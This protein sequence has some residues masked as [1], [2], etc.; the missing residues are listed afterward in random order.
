VSDC[1]VFL[2]FFIHLYAKS[3]FLGQGNSICPSHLPAFFC[4]LGWFHITKI[5]C[6]KRNG[7]K[8]W[9][10]RLEKIDLNEKSWWEP[11]QSS[12]Q[13]Q[14]ATLVG[15][16]HNSQE[17]QHPGLSVNMRRLYCSI[18]YKASDE[19]YNLGWTCMN[20]SCD[21]Y[22]QFADYPDYEDSQLDYNDAFMKNRTPFVGANPGPLA[23]A[24][25]TNRDIDHLGGVGYE[26]AIRKGIVCQ[27]C[28]CCSRRQHWDH[29][30]CENPNCDFTY[31]V[32]Q[33][34][35][36]ISEVWTEK[37]KQ[38][39]PRNVFDRDSVTFSKALCGHY[40]S[41]TYTVPGENGETIGRIHHY[42]SNAVINQQTDGPNDLF[43]LMQEGKFNLKR[44]SARGGNGK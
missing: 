7:H 10:T 43:R 2:S 18:C 22:F 39:T 19:I 31:S 15:G 38:N 30:E 16:A 24:P 11:M 4:V 13:V 36:T 33:N 12:I 44:N 3:R 17:V 37:L 1:H 42:K 9:V 32:T 5:W 25:V 35:L 21:A 20:P 26:V 34:V 6:E 23:P 14:G 41:Y 8:Q 27:K 40:T 29:W 28:G